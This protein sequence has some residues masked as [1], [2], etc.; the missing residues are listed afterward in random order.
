MIRDGRGDDTMFL[1]ITIMKSMG[2]SWE[3]LNNVPERTFL[4]LGRILSLKS[5]HEEAEREKAKNT[6]KHGKGIGGK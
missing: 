6:K 5:K 1:D 2:W 3:E 4:S